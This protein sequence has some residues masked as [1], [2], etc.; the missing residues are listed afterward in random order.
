MTSERINLKDLAKKKLL[1]APGHRLCS[2]CAASIIVKQALLAVDGPIVVVNATGCLEVATTIYPYTSW[3]VPWIHNAFENAA[4][5]ASGI[6][7]ARDKLLADGRLKQ[8]YDIIV[9]GGDGGTYDIGLQSLSGAWERGDK[10][11]YILYDNEAYMNTGIQR[12]GG[13]PMCAWTTTTPV[14]RVVRGKEEWK[15]PIARI[16]AAHKIPYVATATPYHWRDFISK[17]KKGLKADGPAFIHVI[18]PCC[19]GWRFKSSQTLKIAKLA[20]ETCFF[21]L[22]EIINGSEYRLSQPSLVIAKN[23]KLK[24]PVKEYIALQGRF[25]HLLQ[26][27]NQELL[28]RIQETV[29]A[30]WNELLRLC[31]I[32]QS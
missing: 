23:P 17:V 14:G 5:T 7:H 24:K 20:V 6:L 15:K 12:S 21:P 9:F 28:N 8:R 32:S 1:L 22:Y 10:F 4:A 31:G 18:S 2:G 25:K 3:R 29:D 13:T 16:A 11:L 27:E 26:P 19:R 30:E